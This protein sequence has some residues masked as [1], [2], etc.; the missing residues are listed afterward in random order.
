MDSTKPNALITGATKEMERKKHAVWRPV[1]KFVIPQTIE[2]SLSARYRLLL[3][4]FVKPTVLID[5]YVAAHCNVPESD[6]YDKLMRIKIV[7]AQHA[8]VLKPSMK[9]DKPLFA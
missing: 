2:Q 5:R 3:R 6:N 8:S 7:C 9:V 1:H 4:V